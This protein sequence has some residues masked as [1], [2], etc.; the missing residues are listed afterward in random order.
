MSLY[1]GRV[2]INLR[3]WRLQAAS[4]TFILYCYKSRVAFLPRQ[5]FSIYHLLHFHL[6]RFLHVTITHRASN[7][8]LLQGAPVLSVSYFCQRNMFFPHDS[9]NHATRHTQTQTHIARTPS[10]PPPSC[11]GVSSAR[12]SILTHSQHIKRIMPHMLLAACLPAWRGSKSKVIWFPAFLFLFFVSYTLTCFFL[13]VS[14]CSGS[15][16]F[17]PP[18]RS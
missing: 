10:A 16:F 3:C 2:A 11:G 14:E 7:L 5:R 8:L 18:C 13:R 12:E 9:M 4:R 15:S 17:R 6:Q 1:L